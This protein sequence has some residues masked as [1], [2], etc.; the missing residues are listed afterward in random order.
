[1]KDD[2]LPTQRIRKTSSSLYKLTSGEKVDSSATLQSDTQRSLRFWNSKA[3]EFITICKE[4]DLPAIV[5]LKQ[6]IERPTTSEQKMRA[7]K[8]QQIFKEKIRQRENR[9]KKANEEKRRSVTYNKGPINY[10][11]EGKLLEMKPTKSK[12]KLGPL[13]TAIQ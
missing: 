1:M 5:P 9:L 4:E 3:V 8:E 13:L 2:N 10:D 7:I 11:Y 12:E 6:I